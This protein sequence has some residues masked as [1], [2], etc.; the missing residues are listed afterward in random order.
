MKNIVNR[1]TWILI[2]LIGWIILIINKNPDKK[3]YLN[4][5]R[6]LKELCKKHSKYLPDS[7]YVLVNK[8]EL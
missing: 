5:I 6:E 4:F 2:L 8:K 7:D 3:L 1:I